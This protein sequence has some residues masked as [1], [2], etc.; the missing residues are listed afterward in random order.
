MLF[1]VTIRTHYIKKVAFKLGFEAV[2][3]NASILM[4]PLAS[5]KIQFY[6]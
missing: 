4:Q 2:L 5:P 6:L 1:F 3:S